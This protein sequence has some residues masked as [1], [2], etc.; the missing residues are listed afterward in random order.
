MAEPYI[1]TIKDFDFLFKFMFAYFFLRVW[2]ILVGQDIKE[3]EK[4]TKEDYEKTVSRLEAKPEKELTFYEKIELNAAKIALKRMNENPI[5]EDQEK[6]NKQR[7]RLFMFIFLSFSMLM[8]AFTM[9]GFLDVPVGEVVSIAIFIFITA[10]LLKYLFEFVVTDNQ[11][12]MIILSGFA[13]YASSLHEI[14]KRI[15]AEF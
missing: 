3:E 7:R 9:I 13:L 12:R 2:A 10:S 14:V 6:L 8:F 1:P 11:F 15:S 4:R 5:S